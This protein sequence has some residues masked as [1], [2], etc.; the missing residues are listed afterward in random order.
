MCECV[1]YNC[2]PLTLFIF[3]CLAVCHSCFVFF[4]VQFLSSNKLKKVS[5]VEG[6]LRSLQLRRLKADVSCNLFAQPLCLRLQ[7]SQPWLVPPHFGQ[8]GP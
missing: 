5:E 6:R 1:L 8:L 7:A 4:K 3:V 2:H